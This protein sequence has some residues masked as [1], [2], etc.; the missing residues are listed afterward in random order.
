MS[1]PGLASLAMTSSMAALDCAQTRI[2]NL[3]ATTGAESDPAL[4][5][6][7]PC[8]AVATAARALVPAFEEEE[9][10]MASGPAASGARLAADS[11]GTGCLAL[12][13]SLGVGG[14]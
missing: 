7:A 5:L 14:V 9:D 8:P 1:K 10:G 12:G 2:L 13:L 11:L 4:A 3:G 6:A